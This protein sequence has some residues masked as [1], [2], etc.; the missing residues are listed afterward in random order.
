MILGRLFD[1]V[2]GGTRQRLRT[3]R[4]HALLERADSLLKS[5][6][7]AGA[8]R[9][10]VD[11]LQ[12]DDNTSGAHAQ[13]AMLLTGSGRLAEA[14]GHYHAADAQQA[15]RGE[16]LDRQVVAGLEGV[17]RPLAAAP[18]LVLVLLRR[19]HLSSNRAR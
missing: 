17:L 19:R 11:V 2:R 6:D 5:G 1:A 18:V 9:C 10:Y 4:V 8:E 14:V 3:R 13:L 12:L 7:L 16:V 15:L